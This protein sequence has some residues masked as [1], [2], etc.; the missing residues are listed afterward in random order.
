MAEFR[1]NDLIK[2]N[3]IEM[4]CAASNHRYFV[5]TMTRYI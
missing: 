1:N 4:K 5:E 3:S 2:V